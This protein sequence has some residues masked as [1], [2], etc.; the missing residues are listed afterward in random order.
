[1]V[2]TVLLLGFLL[3]ATTTDVLRHKIFN[4]TTYPGI[5]AALALNGLGDLL[6]G[7]AG[8]DPE[9][10]RALGWIGLADS[11][12]GLLVCGG[13]LLACFV[14]FKIGGGDVKLMAMM[15]TML[16]TDRGMMALLWTFVIG[17]CTGLIVLVWRLGPWRIAAGVTR[18]VLWLFHVRRFSPLT[19]EE[20]AELQAPIYLAPSALGAA[21][22]V[23]F[24]LLDR[25]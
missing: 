19:P 24:G 5:L 6:I 10:L 18:Q 7:R 25:L 23:Q 16:G 21:L 12:Y 20:R 17:G 2:R 14:V 15:G 22:I 9:V 11:F 13:L 1:M 8:T 4:W 3:V